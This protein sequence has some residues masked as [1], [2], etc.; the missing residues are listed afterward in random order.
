MRVL[1][2][3]LLLVA[4]ATARA[5]AQ[6]P[7]ITPAGDPSVRSDT[8]YRL[9]VNPADHPDEGFVYLFDDG[10]VRV[11][12]DGRG[13]RSYRQVIQV[14]KQ[15]AAQQ[16]G[17]QIISYLRSRERL[18]VNWIRLLRAD[19]TVVSDTA[20]HE[21]ESDA[22]AALAYPVYSDLRLHRITIGG[23]A[24]GMIVDRSYTIETLDPMLPGDFLTRWRFTVGETE[25]R[26]RFILDVPASLAPRIVQHN[27]RFEPSISE[28]HGRRVYAWTTQEVP[29]RPD[30]EPFAADSND[31]NAFVAVASPESWD[32]VARWYAGLANDRY[33]VAP[34]LEARLAE[35]VGGQRTRDDSLRALYRWVAQDFRYVSIA[36]GM[37]G[38]QPRP[39]AVTFETKFGDCKDKVTLFVALARRMG[40]QAFP[41]L[42]N[43]NGGTDSS[44]VSLR[45]FN[46]VIAAVEQPA[47]YLY[48]DPTAEAVP[49]GALPPSEGGAFG[50][51]VRPDGRVEHIHLPLDSVT[52]NRADFELAGAIG[53][54]G[55]FTGRATQRYAGS[56]ALGARMSYSRDIS[57][58]RRA[59]MLRA[60]A[61]GTFEGAEGDSLELFDGR[62]LTAPARITFIVRNGKATTNAGTTDILT[63]PLRPLIPSAIVSEV[64][65]HGPRRFH[66]AAARVLGDGERTWE[67]RFTLPEGWRARLPAG[68]SASSIFGSYTSTYTQEGRELRVVRRAVGAR[69]V[70]PADKVDELLAFLRAIARDDAHF[71]VLEHP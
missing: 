28:S 44:L 71:V 23:V 56:F 43:A 53:A 35:V 34:E 69:G 67:M 14:L 64:A 11:E 50:L 58:A 59:Q 51:L 62:D 19:G 13:T 12:A 41:V 60:M 22:P 25:R 6:A 45:Q 24:P 66:I 31:F 5:R 55:S 7:V 46:H 52:A 21:Q 27:L 29:R 18:T 37:A 32:D 16:I 47:G 63:L 70:L 61:G 8:I 4:T 57:A 30:P 38:Y 65:A 48:L 15:E 10:V 54:D 42:V 39:P 2:P 36:L 33:T 26:S 49:V 9:A 17:E 3:A 68:V 20:A 1:L 40:F